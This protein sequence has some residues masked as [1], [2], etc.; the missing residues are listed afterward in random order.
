MGPKLVASLLVENPLEAS[1]TYRHHCKSLSRAYRV[2]TSPHPPAPRPT[3]ASCGL[4]TS[5]RNAP[6]PPAC[7]QQAPH[8]A[9]FTGTSV[10]AQHPCSPPGRGWACLTATAQLLAV[11]GVQQGLSRH[12]CMVW[13]RRT[14]GLTRA[15]LQ[16]KDTQQ[17]LLWP[18]WPA[19]PGYCDIDI[20]LELSASSL[21]LFSTLH[22][23]Y[24]AQ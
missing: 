21:V 22:G 13:G 11:P 3:E 8:G 1:H 14:R 18:W 2:H 12:L 17:F 10:T 20:S 5:A 7:P 24:L 23:K 16:L 9:L 4:F 19:V 15:P 6:S